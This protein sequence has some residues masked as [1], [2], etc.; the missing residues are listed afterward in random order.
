MGIEDIKPLNR[1][2][3]IKKVTH[4]QTK[5]PSPIEKEVDMDVSS[6]YVPTKTKDNLL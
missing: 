2:L 6:S 5:K 4:E 3:S 1:R